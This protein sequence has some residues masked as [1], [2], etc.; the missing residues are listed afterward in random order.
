MIRRLEKVLRSGSGQM[1]RR[2]KGG[3]VCGK[4]KAMEAAPVK[5]TAPFPSEEARNYLCVLC[6]HDHFVNDT[7]IS[8][9]FF[10]AGHCLSST[11]WAMPAPM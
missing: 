7:N 11:P 8:G 10:D 3:R 2:L 4:R 6:A 1:I 9:S 5:P